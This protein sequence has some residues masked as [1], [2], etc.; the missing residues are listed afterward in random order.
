M[1]CLPPL[2][3]VSVSALRQLSWQPLLQGRDWDRMDW[4]HGHGVHKV[5]RSSGVVCPSDAEDMKL[6]CAV[7]MIPM[8]SFRGLH[9]FKGHKLLGTLSPNAFKRYRLWTPQVSGLKP[10]PQCCP[11]VASFIG[12]V[13]VVDFL[14]FKS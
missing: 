2:P 7:Y 3:A 5:V 13:V 8:E 11:M 12:L 6:W 14:Q 9:Y 1:E 4:F 10:N